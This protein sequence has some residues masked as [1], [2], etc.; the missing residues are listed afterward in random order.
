MKRI[1]YALVVVCIVGASAVTLALSPS[2]YRKI[3]VIQGDDVG[4]CVFSSTE[5]T[6][7]TNEASFTP[8]DSLKC[9]QD[10]FARCYFPRPMGEFKGAESFQALLDVHGT[11]FTTNFPA[12][13]DRDSLNF[14][15]RA[16]VSI[17]R[18]AKGWLDLLCTQSHKSFDANI[19]LE[20]RAKFPKGYHKELAVKR[21]PAGSSQ[22]EIKVVEET[23]RDVDYTPI[24]K[25]SLKLKVS[26]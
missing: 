13:P 20:I 9:G 5:L 19:S 22:S 11:Q 24:A 8:S 26:K 14:P 25:G 6:S 16:A 17:N 10:I 2:K 7:D 23:Y 1:C 4:N 18:D 12:K 3:D 15:L 21:E